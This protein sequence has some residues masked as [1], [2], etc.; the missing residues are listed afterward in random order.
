MTIFQRYDAEPDNEPE[1]SEWCRDS[2]ITRQK[3][4]RRRHCVDKNQ[5]EDWLSSSKT[6]AEVGAAYDLSTSV[7]GQRSDALMSQ[8]KFVLSPD[9]LDREQNV[10]NRKSISAFTHPLSCQRF[11]ID[12][13]ETS[14][15]NFARR[16]TNT[17]RVTRSIE[18]EMMSGDDL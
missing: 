8:T 6:N 14:V 3:I 9:L 11:N 5:T 4:T 13:L 15:T 7:I 12:I 17:K 18:N 1:S 16:M 2:C 10:R